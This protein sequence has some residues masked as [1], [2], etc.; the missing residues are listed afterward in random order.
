[1]DSKVIDLCREI[2]KAGLWTRWDEA[3]DL[4]CLVVGG[5]DSVSF[6]QS[7]LTSDV[8]ALQPYGYQMSARVDRKGQLVAWFSLHRMPD[9]GQPFPVF[10]L[11][12]SRAMVSL[13]QASLEK[14]IIT[15]DVFL[16][17]GSEQYSG[18][19]LTGDN[20][21]E[22]DFGSLLSFPSRLT[23]DFGR[24]ILWPS[25]GDDSQFSEVIARANEHELVHLDNSEESKEA[26][27]SLQLEAGWPI[28]GRDLEPGSM[29][30]LQTGLERHVVSTTKGC[31]LGQEVLARIR[32][33]G[34]VKMAM[35]G[36][37]FMDTPQ[38]E[39]LPATGEKIEDNEGNK[40]GIWGT[41]TYSTI[42]DAKVALAFLDRQNRTPGGELVLKTTAGE[43]CAKIILL[44][45]YDAGAPAER[46]RSLYERA[47]HLFSLGQDLKAA[48][49]L[50]EAIGLDPGHG[51]AYEALG[52]ILGRGERYHEAI[53]IFHRLEEVAPDE[54]MVHTNLSLYYMKI[55]NREEAER[56]RALSTMKQFGV[57]DPEVLRQQE[58]KNRQ[59]MLEE[60]GR[61]QV[62]FSEVLAMDPSDS[63]ALMGMGNALIE[64]GQYDDAEYCLGKAVAEQANNSSLY[65]S[66]GKVLE[67]LGRTDEARGV[68]QR[69]VEVASRRGDLMP[70]REMEHR[71]LLLG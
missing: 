44:P 15:E 55:G 70:L 67:K 22:E 33:Y 32:S 41:Q 37:V 48:N 50:E 40:I 57:D 20:I 61:K 49:L 17:N 64:L 52:V 8:A 28:M 51:D 30:L 6:L 1:M 62:M 69:G 3:P 47:V 27:A 65:L 46:A 36:L 43:L 38:P 2:R 34:S 16:E 42:W 23:G 24:L 54:P 18:I 59:L 21:E 31:Y 35:R 29:V 14:Y 19:M 25:G 5:P 56:Q 9:R 39:Y 63:L 11:V 66:H 53:D 7:Q 13:I 71:L 68:L 45:F 60:A 26:W 58:E 10:M 4:G 12:M